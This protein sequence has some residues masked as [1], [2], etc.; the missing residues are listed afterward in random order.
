MSDFSPTEGGFWVADEPTGRG[1]ADCTDLS[2]NCLTMHLNTRE[3]RSNTA[4]TQRNT[5]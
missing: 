2:T 4:M 3:W 5:G 1:T